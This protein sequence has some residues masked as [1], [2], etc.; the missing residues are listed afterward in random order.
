MRCWCVTV[1][2]PVPV[3]LHVP[4]LLWAIASIWRHRMPAH[5]DI[6]MVLQMGHLSQHHLPDVHTCFGLGCVRL[7]QYTSF[8]QL[9]SKLLLAAAEGTR[10]E[11]A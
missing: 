4:L 5:G 7:Q 1:V 8:E 6:R 10:F 3:P 11:E 2:V 9:G